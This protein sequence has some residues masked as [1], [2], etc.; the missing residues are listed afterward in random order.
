MPELAWDTIIAGLIG[1][2][3]QKPRTAGI[4][5]VIDTGVGLRQ[6]QD[7]L[8]LAGHCIDHWKFGFGT[9]VFHTRKVLEEKLGRLADQGILSYPGGTLL[10]V[11]LVEHHCR[12]Y[13]KHAVD[14]GFCAME[15]SDGTIPLPPFRRR[16]MIRCARDAGLIPITEV[17]KKDPRKQPTATEVAEQALEDLENGAEWV[18]VEGRESGKDVGIYD[19]HGQVIND[20][21]TSIRDALGAAAA[22]LIWEAPLQ[23][24]QTYLIRRFGTNVGL[25]NIH[26]DQVLAVESLRCRLRFDTLHWIT[27]ELMRTGV[28]NPDKVETHGIGLPLARTTP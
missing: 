9:S 3:L 23:D 1:D 26:P 27:D 18:V 10:E 7:I 4:T 16:N 28:W 12:D 20:S 15:I 24:Q 2:R 8:E 21:V 13:M 6:M 22:R 19:Q 14:L 11:A 17:G 5:M 25:G